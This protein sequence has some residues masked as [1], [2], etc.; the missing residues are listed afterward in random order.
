MAV[1][2]VLTGGGRKWQSLA[3]EWGNGLKKDL[4]MGSEKMD[5]EAA[6]WII[7]SR[8]KKPDEVEK[9]LMAA[10]LRVWPRAEAY[11]RRELCDSPI[12]EETGVISEAWE[13]SLQSVLRSLRRNFRLRPIRNLDS[14]IFGVFAHRLKRVLSREKI[15]EFVPTNK[16]L[17]EL[18]GA[19]DWNWV[20]NLENVLELKR[21]VSK[22]DDWMKEVCFRRSFGDSWAVIAKDSGITEHQAKM[23]FFDRFKKIRQRILESEKTSA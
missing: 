10:A 14:Y 6:V 23:R 13:V 1:D 9:D 8:N 20:T 17:A 2:G 16:E 7:A 11:A 15:I 18:R 5:S 19:Q 4:G 12:A 22:M 21:T 3:S